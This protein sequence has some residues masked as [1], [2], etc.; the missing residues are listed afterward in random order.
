[1]VLLK[2]ES[3]GWSLHWM[4]LCVWNCNKQ[5]LLH[6]TWHIA[7]CNDD[8]NV[9]MVHKS[10][11]W[12]EDPPMCHIGSMEAWLID[13]WCQ[14]REIQGLVNGEMATR[15]EVEPKWSQITGEIMAAWMVAPSL[16]YVCRNWPWNVN[17]LF[18]VMKLYFWGVKYWKGFQCH[19]WNQIWRSSTT[20]DIK[21]PPADTQIK[22]WMEKMQI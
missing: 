9:W 20:E 18:Q 19:L 7:L 16:W 4:L 10:P 21:E 14:G 11:N 1:M 6:Y 15:V 22:I 2:E 5:L 12:G 13:R 8:T 3:L 17:N